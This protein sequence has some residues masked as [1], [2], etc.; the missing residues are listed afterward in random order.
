[1]LQIPGAKDPDEYIKKY[2]AER[3]KALLD[4]VGN[5]LDFRLGRLRSQYDL[6]QDAQRLEYVKQAVDL[7]AERSSP[8]EQEVYAGRLAEETNIS[9]TAIMTQLETAVKRVGSKRRYEK[10]KAV[11]QS[12][13]MNLDRIARGM[14]VASKAASMTNEE[15]S[16]YFQSMREKKQ[17]LVCEEE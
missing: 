16:S 2:G 5:A 9:K 3:F 1:M 13:E 14:P 15:L 7:L 12:G 8:T 17:G 4:G 10:K 6:S 11:L